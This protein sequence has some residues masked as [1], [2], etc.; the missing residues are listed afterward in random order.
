MNMSIF[1]RIVV[2]VS[3]SNRNCDIGLSLLFLSY[4]SA[5]VDLWSMQM[6]YTVSSA[7]DLGADRPGTV[8]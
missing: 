1:R 2:V 7:K 6:G 4:I 5:S 3:Q 8:H